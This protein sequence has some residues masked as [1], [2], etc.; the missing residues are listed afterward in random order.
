MVFNHKTLNIGS[1][2]DFLYIVCYYLL[3]NLSTYIP[4]TYLATALTV[5]NIKTCHFCSI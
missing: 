2:L 5:K 1:N 3:A 4:S